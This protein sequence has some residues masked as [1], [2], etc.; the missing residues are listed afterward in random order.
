VA[1]D[2][3]GAVLADRDEDLGVVAPAVRHPVGAELLLLREERLGKPDG[4]D[5]GARAGAGQESA[6]A[7]V[8]QPAGEVDDVLAHSRTPFAACLIAARMRG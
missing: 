8:L 1:G 7:D 3:D 5:E 4:Q 2:R 6:A